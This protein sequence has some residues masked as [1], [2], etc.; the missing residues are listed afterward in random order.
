MKP[1]DVDHFPVRTHS[2]SIFYQ[3]YWVGLDW[4][5]TKLCS[6]L[7]MQN[8]CP[9]RILLRV[10]EFVILRSA[11]GVSRFCLWGKIG[12]VQRIGPVM[13]CGY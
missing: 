12:E 6:T 8:L 1:S 4:E 7:S 11:L 2:S 13:V 10:F 3:F 5:I 9:C